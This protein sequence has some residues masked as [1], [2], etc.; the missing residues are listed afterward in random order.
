MKADSYTD[1]TNETYQQNIDNSNNKFMSIVKSLETELNIEN[2]QK[3][4][5]ESQGVRL[6]HEF[7]EEVERVE[8]N[9]LRVLVKK[10]LGLI[11]WE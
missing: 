3:L 7:M 11:P 4:Q 6:T 8:P 9:D 1:N 10:I 2:L 5:A